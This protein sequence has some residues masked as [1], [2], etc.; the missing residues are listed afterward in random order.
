MNHFHKVT[1]LSIKLPN[2]KYKKLSHALDFQPS[3]LQPDAFQALQAFLK[4]PHN[5][6]MILSTF[7]GAFSEKWLKS[8]L[9]NENWESIQGAD[10][11]G[12][13]HPNQ[14]TTVH[15]F[16]VQP[17]L[18]RA[19]LDQMF[20]H[21]QKKKRHETVDFLSLT[22]FQDK[23]DSLIDYLELL[24]QCTN[25]DLPIKTDAFLI[26]QSQQ[27]QNSIVF[28]HMLSWETLFGH[29]HVEQYNGRC[30]LKSGLV[31]Q[32]NHGLLVLP[33]QE[34]VQQPHL[35]FNLKNQLNNQKLNWMYNPHHLTSAPFVDVTPIS[36]QV[37]ILLTGNANAISD[38]QQ[39]DPDAFTKRVLYAEILPQ[40]QLPTQFD[41]YLSWINQVRIR[42]GISLDFHQQAIEVLLKF[43]AR[44]T[45]NHRE[46]PF[47]EAQIGSLMHIAAQKAQETQQD[48]VNDTH[49][50]QAIDIINMPSKRLSVELDRSIEEGFTFLQT[51]GKAIGQINALTV[52]HLD[53]HP[54]TIGETTRLTATVHLGDGELIDIDKKAELSGHIHNKSMLIIHS[55]ITNNFGIEHQCPFSAA[56]TFEQSYNEIDGDS[57]SLAGLC[58][59][60]SA[61][62]EVP[63]KQNFAVTGAIDQFGH[64]LAVGGINE[65]IDG[66]FRACKIQG[67]T[68]DQAVIIPK[69]NCLQLQ[70]SHEIQE[71]V[72]QEKFHIYSVSH[73]EEAIELLTGHP[74][75]EFEGAHTTEDQ[76]IFTKIQVRL[77]H[78]NEHDTHH[79]YHSSWFSR[80]FGTHDK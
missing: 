20:E 14:P 17:G 54:Y 47:D 22:H 64:V 57:A 50:W 35:W 25:D 40:I 45:E 61:L 75:R 32:A 10:L 38:F 53:G 6:W 1:D 4:M 68:G 73:V 65:K 77:R 3:L 59:L 15:L 8:L 66:F 63:I 71:A 74:A 43:L 39:I 78:A 60:L 51:K 34:L 58:A 31:H 46:L 44:I 28:S 27:D 76:F 11:C 12:I 41:A 21:I 30:K 80:W 16:Y 42:N 55:F 69:M 9:K 7:D 24:N 36:A 70:L 48:I 26:L 37:K 23:D 67:I 72:H 56:L 19:F 33:L 18:G 52:L 5:S 13:S 49:M 62:S 29:L 2:I 79:N